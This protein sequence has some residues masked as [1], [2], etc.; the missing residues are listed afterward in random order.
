MDEVKNQFFENITHEFRT[1]LTLIDSPLQ[2]L[3]KDNQTTPEAKTKIELI[4]SQSSRLLELVDQILSLNQLKNGEINVL[5]K[6]I[7]P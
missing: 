6:K 5:L 4:R 7:K 2:L 1:P 3:S